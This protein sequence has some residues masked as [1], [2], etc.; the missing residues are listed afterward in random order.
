MA[1][2][3][4]RTASGH[5]HGYG[6]RPSAG[7]S[8]PFSRGRPLTS[9]RG[10]GRGAWHVAA[11]CRSPRWSRCAG[12]RWAWRRRVL[13]GR[14]WPTVR[15]S[16]V[17]SPVSA[18]TP[19][20]SRWTG[21]PAP[22][23]RSVPQSIRPRHL[24]CARAVIRAGRVGVEASWASARL[25]ATRQTLAEQRQFRAYAGGRSD[26]RSG[27]TAPWSTARDLGSRPQL[28][29]SFPQGFDA[30]GG[31]FSAATA[32]HGP[33]TRRPRRPRARLASV[34]CQRARLTVTQMGECCRIPHPCRPRSRKSTRGPFPVVLTAPVNAAEAPRAGAVHFECRGHLSV[35]GVPI[36]GC[37][38]GR[39]RRVSPRI[40]PPATRRT[41]SAH[42]CPPTSPWE[43]PR[44][45]STGVEAA[46]AGV[47]TDDQS[48][49]GQSLVPVH[50]RWQT[51]APASGSGMTGWT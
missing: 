19:R 21:G 4:L 34:S 26:R 7:R 29:G 51:P 41:C 14:L 28:A 18:R 38:C 39:L 16:L 17:R 25:A 10:N 32:T 2:A 1:P 44:R 37:P 22:G 30:L 48:H 24:M 47:L 43:W 6:T 33:C 5:G 8:A 36:G 45:L 35:P 15:V 12:P 50:G 40:T 9:R 46:N 13:S 27:G 42:P 23:V 31:A 3:L 20:T 11:G 49:S